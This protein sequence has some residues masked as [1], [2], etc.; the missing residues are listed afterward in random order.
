MQPR[1][2]QTIRDLAVYTHPG[3]AAA[4]GAA[5]GGAAAGGADTPG[6]AAE[7]M[8]NLV[9]IHGTLDR[10]AGMLP[11][12]R[13]LRE[14]N[15]TRYDR[16]GYGR[17]FA[18]GPAESFATQLADLEAVINGQRSVLFGHSYGGVLALALAA[19]RH[20]D[21]AAVVT[22]EAPRAWEPWWTA[23]PADDLLE[24]AAAMDAAEQFCRAMMGDQI[25]E[26]LPL[27]TRQARRAEG[28][29]MITELQHQYVR[30]YD[31]SEIAVPVVVGVG[32]LSG[33][34]TQRAAKLTADEAAV[35]ATASEI[36]SVAGAGH[37]APMTHA[38]E[39]AGLV[40][41]AFDLI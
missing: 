40:R 3:G 32:E 34:R 20:R 33:P 19:Q 35:G 18:T 4:G 17:S 24:P 41:R 30:Q 2:R 23:P 36:R 25:W 9:L 38:N 21:V 39:V 8:P 11:L 27:A 13:R 16:R 14:F 37:G 5:A 29:A 22:F 10:G 28:T 15:I 6:A 12:A 31:A 1:R 26:G 7:G